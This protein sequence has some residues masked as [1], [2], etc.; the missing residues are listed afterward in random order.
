MIPLQCLQI[1][2]HNALA[3]SVQMP[4][5]ISFASGHSLIEVM[6][7][8]T[9]AAVAQMSLAGTRKLSIPHLIA[10]SDQVQD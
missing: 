3:S 8:F 4:C 7:F 5:C 1:G 6:Q 2:H 10:R 9:A